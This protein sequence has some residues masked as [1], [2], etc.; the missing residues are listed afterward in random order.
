MGAPPAVVK[1]LVQSVPFL[2]S[3]DPLVTAQIIRDLQL[4]GYLSREQDGRIRI[5]ERL[6]G[7]YRPPDSVSM[8]VG[9]ALGPLDEGCCG[10]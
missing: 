9:R 3:G 8:V 7:E 10:C 4:G 5:S 1:A 2:A 6:Y